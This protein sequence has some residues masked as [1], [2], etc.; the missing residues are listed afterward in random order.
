MRALL[1]RFVRD[2]RGMETIEWAIM[3]SLLVVGLIAIL[4]WVGGAIITKWGVVQ[5]ALT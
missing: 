1:R 2:E 4:I 3:L 5:T